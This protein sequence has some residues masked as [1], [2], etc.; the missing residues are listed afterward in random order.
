MYTGYIS[1]KGENVWSQYKNTEYSS[2][3]SWG[4][5]KHNYDIMTK[6]NSSQHMQTNIRTI[7][8]WQPPVLRLCII[9][10]LSSFQ[11]S[12]VISFPQIN[13]T[14]NVLLWSLYSHS[15]STDLFMHNSVHLWG[16]W[17]REGAN[18]AMSYNSTW[19]SVHKENQVDSNMQKGKWSQKFD[20]FL[21][22]AH[23]A[24]TC[25]IKLD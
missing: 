15:L 19:N 4:I 3:W 1:V 17:G 23:E 25:N 22:S 11:I 8:S 13:S 2:Q 7:L 6:D 10:D 9:S 16:E 5:G 20:L 14:V 12:L 18:K 21:C 24:A